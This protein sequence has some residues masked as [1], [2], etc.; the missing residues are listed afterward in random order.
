MEYHII[1][2]VCKTRRRST[3][4]LVRHLDD[5]VQFLVETNDACGVD[6]LVVG[7][8][9]VYVRGGVEMC[10]VDLF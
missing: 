6:L 7:E 8:R 4:V 9:H 1:V 5:A 2:W 3:K 10:V